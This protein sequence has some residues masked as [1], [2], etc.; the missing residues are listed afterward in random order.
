MEDQVCKYYE[1]TDNMHVDFMKAM[2]DL[3]LLN[4][5]NVK[6]GEQLRDAQRPHECHDGFGMSKAIPT[7][8]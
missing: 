2:M 4:V 1:S 3:V 6:V 8:T 7:K 5:M